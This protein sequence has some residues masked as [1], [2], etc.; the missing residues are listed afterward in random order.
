MGED[1]I[2]A[3]TTTQSQSST[4]IS[5]PAVGKEE[6]KEIFLGAVATSGYKAMQQVIFLQHELQ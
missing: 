2:S 1:I 4:E 6:G 5:E 3:G